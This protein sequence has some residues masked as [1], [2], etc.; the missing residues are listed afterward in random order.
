MELQ[1]HMNN[2]LGP[3]KTI[4]QD[5]HLSQEIDLDLSRWPSQSNPED[6]LYFLKKFTCYYDTTLPSQTECNYI[7]DL[8]KHTP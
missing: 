2:K 3:N 1:M 8:K 6:M 7:K 5:P 4:L